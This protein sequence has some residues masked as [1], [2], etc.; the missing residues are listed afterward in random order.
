MSH[1]DKIASLSTPGHYVLILLFLQQLCDAGT[2]YLFFT[3]I[4][5]NL[6]IYKF[7][8]YNLF[9]M[10]SSFIYNLHIGK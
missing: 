2:T 4:I 8:I 1:V 6:P 5:Y 10:Y 3:F 7:T 9:I